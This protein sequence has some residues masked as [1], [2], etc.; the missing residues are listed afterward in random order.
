MML[1]SPDIEEPD[2]WLFSIVKQCF[3]HSVGENRF[4]KSNE[5]QH[6]DMVLSRQEK[7]KNALLTVDRSQINK[8]SHKPLFEN[9][10]KRDFFLRNQI[11]CL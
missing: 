10:V 3:C 5:N 8:S 1:L 9:E 6:T 11:N 7:E 2:G 4:H